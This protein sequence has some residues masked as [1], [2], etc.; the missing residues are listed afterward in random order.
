M[1]PTMKSGRFFKTGSRI[2]RSGPATAPSSSNFRRRLILS[3][4]IFTLLVLVTIAFVSHLIFEDL[5]Y[6]AIKQHLDDGISEMKKQFTGA[7]GEDSLSQDPAPS[8]ASEVSDDLDRSIPLPP[9]PI[10]L[11]R[12]P[13]EP[14]LSSGF[15]R[16]VVSVG[17]TFTVRDRTGRIV[18]TGR[19]LRRETRLE[20][21]RKERQAPPGQRP[22]L[23]EWDLGDNRKAEVLALDEPM[24][25]AGEIVARVGMT[26]EQAEKVIQPIRRLLITKTLIGS[27]LTLAIL[28]FA[29][30][31]ILRL[32]QRTR[33]LEA[34]AQMAERRAHV[35]TLAREMAHEIRNPLNAMSMN[36]EMLEEEITGRLSGDRAEVGLFLGGIKGE[37]RRLRDLAE[38]FLS[39]AKPL[40]LNFDGRDLNRFL[41]EICAFI[42]PEVDARRIVLMR[43]LDPML[44]SVEFD[45]A[46]F[47]QA[48]VNI[49]NN[50][51]QAVPERG[52]IRVKS[53]VDP[54]GE[55]RVSIGDTGPGMT[56]EVLESIFQP[57]YSRREG[58][59]G[60]GLPI[61]RRAVEA[62]GGRIQVESEPGQGATFHI[63]LPRRQPEAAGGAEGSA[64]PVAAAAEN[65]DALRQAR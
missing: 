25:T 35:A 63:F 55:V 65:T 13:L 18:M 40:Q 50:A 1:I 14:P 39:Y 43:D 34:E 23:E 60:L 46:Q 5:S 41:E 52:V 32:V 56:P 26:R 28:G 3:A 12:Q 58:G 22:V 44:P 2:L 59:S 30:W 51:Q 53:R 10:S 7:E 54:G 9:P 61:A 20:P 8:A 37:I 64:S 57:F 49:L 11:E 45:S 27:A 36:L 62:H 48:I 19:L 17:K 47:R 4:T 33:R 38:N 16:T 21:I 42:R 29:F 31:Y 6:R 15:R 24:D